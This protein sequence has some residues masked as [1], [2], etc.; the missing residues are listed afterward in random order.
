MLSAASA[1]GEER[2]A[3]RQRGDVSSLV[4]AVRAAARFDDELQ[5]NFVY[6]EQRRDIRMSK[7]GK[8]TVGPSRTFEVHPSSE[9]GRTWKRLIAIDGKPLDP[10]ELQRRDEEHARDV[11]EREEHERNESS[12]ARTRRLQREADDRREREAILD[13]AVAVYEPREIGRETLDGEAVIVAD[14][15]P[16]PDAHVTT[17]YGR[18]MKQ[19]AGRIWIA[20]S[21]SLIAALEMRAIDD[22]S[23][24]W[25]VL[26][27]LHEGSRFY[28]RRRKVDGTW[29]PSEVTYEASGRTLLFRPFKVKA[30]TTYSGYRRKPDLSSR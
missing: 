16:R 9:P 8:V 2:R 14:L 19:F 21:S 11:R 27:R 28:V 10:A 6:I 18:W 29:L 22:V 25:G 24:G 7:L 15:T 17:R 23:I 5:E 30:V 4:H 3:A 20:E 13:D 26:G 12:S 1:A